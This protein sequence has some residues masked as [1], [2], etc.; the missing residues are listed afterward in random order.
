[1]G[2]CGP[3]GLLT[4]HFKLRQVRMQEIQ[5]CPGNAQFAK[6]WFHIQDVDMDV[7]A[8]DAAIERTYV[9]PV[10]ECI[11]LN[12][13]LISA[14]ALLADLQGICQIA[15]GYRVRHPLAPHR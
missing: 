12:T 14:T 1:M 13:A 7:L 5:Q 4:D 10:P 3:E 2:A 9:L 11:E 15:I 8:T 6:C